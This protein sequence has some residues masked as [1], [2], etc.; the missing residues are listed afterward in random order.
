MCPPVRRAREGVGRGSGG[1][2]EG[3]E[4]GKSGSLRG[5]ASRTLVGR[6]AR[7]PDSR[8]CTPCWRS[9]PREATES[10]DW[11]RSRAQDGQSLHSPSPRVPAAR[12]T[13]LP[14]D[15]AGS[16]RLSAATGGRQPRVGHLLS[17]RL[18]NTA[19]EDFLSCNL[20]VF[21]LESTQ[22]HRIFT[23]FASYLPYFPTYWPTLQ[24]SLRVS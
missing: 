19:N 13:R 6:K 21:S 10:G 20:T 7:A 1:S 22:F 5:A 24:K 9:R 3:G 18:A 2:A 14:D 16:A 4:R 12:L 11:E 8:A 15:A 17:P 23:V